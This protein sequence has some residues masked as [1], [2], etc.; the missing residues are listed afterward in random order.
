[1][2]KLIYANAEV[3][4][5]HLAKL[6]LARALNVQTFLVE[7]GQLPR[8]RIFLKE[9]DILEAPKEETTHRARVELGAS[10]R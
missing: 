8:D 3:T 10:V 9:P 6:A 2:E 7:S 5:D 4:D 1:M